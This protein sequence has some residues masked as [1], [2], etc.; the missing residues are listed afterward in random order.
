MSNYLSIYQQQRAELLKRRGGLVPGHPDSVATTWSLA[1]E[2]VEGAN[3]A[4][5][6]LMRFCAYLS[7]D[8]I[9]E[10][11]IIE[12]APHLGP[13]LQPVAA[14][15]SRLNAAIAELLKYSL[16]RRD[17]TTHTLTIHRLVQAVIKD[18]M[19]E[20][21]QRQWA[22]RAVQATSQV[23]PFDEPPPWSRSQR[24]L[25]HALVC[26]ELIKEWNLTLDEAAALLNNAGCYLRNRGQYR[27]AEPLLQYALTI[28]ENTVRARSSQ[29][30][31][32]AQQ[33]GNPLQE[34]GQVRGGR[35]ALPARPGHQRK[36]AWPWST[37]L[38]RTHSTTWQ[39]ST[40]TRASTRRPSPSSSVPWPS[41]KRRLA[42]S[43]P[44]PRTHSTTWHSSTDQG[45]YEE[46]EPLYQRALTIREKA[47]GPEH[48]DTASTLNNLAL[49]YNNQGK[50]EEAEPLY[51][52]ALAIREKAL[53]PEHP[54]TAS[55]LNNLAILYYDQGKD[56]EAEPLYQRAL[57]IR[58]K[59][60]GLDHPYTKRTRENYTNLLQKMG[61]KTE[62]VDQQN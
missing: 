43:T 40:L 9:P 57:A 26:E 17:A 53:G 22:E 58:E 14:D 2:H 23:F 41:K 56:E 16:I 30:R 52:R 21:T 38:Q 51:Q 54:D 55:T 13:V 20:E 45:K 7:P 19:D 47:L 25:P 10:E 36:G 61:Q 18:E 12:G 48:P 15:R 11:L 33:P 3:P 24:Y 62:G 31:F 50:Y 60:F 42:L 44:I 5:I 29:H 37:P 35:A 39:S 8:A 1:F 59:V 49:L 46:A 28:G 34:P 4:A 32:P 27:E 6:E